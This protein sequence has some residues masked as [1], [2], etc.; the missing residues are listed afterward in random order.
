MRKVLTPGWRRYA[1]GLAVVGSSLGVMGAQCQPP[2]PP[3]PPPTGLSISPTSH[4]FGNDVTD[5]GVTLGNQ[6]FTVT[7]NGPG[8]SGTLQVTKD[9]YN[10][11]NFNIQPNTCDGASLPAGDTCTVKVYFEAHHSPGPRLANLI[12]SSDEPADGTAIAELIG[13]ATAA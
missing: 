2:K 11:D 13:T 3:P 9:L 5:D 8:T 7:N 10:P 12:V 6:D 1:L 4:D